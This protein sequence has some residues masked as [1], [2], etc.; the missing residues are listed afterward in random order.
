M[1]KKEYLKQEH[2]PVIS[3]AQL[4]KLFADLLLWY[5]AQYC[6]TIEGAGEVVGEYMSDKMKN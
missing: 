2:L 1:T 6:K 3:T 5:D 4:S